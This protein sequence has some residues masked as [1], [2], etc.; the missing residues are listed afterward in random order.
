MEKP[1]VRIKPFE[2]NQEADHGIVGEDQDGNDAGQQHQVHGQLF[3]EFHQR[4]LFPIVWHSIHIPCNMILLPESTAIRQQK[5]L[6]G[7]IAGPAT[8]FTAFTSAVM[9]S[10]PRDFQL[11][12]YL[13]NS[14]TGTDPMMILVKVSS[15]SCLSVAPLSVMDTV[16]ALM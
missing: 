16:S 12:T 2:C 3:F 13:S 9:S 6:V 11:E 8:Y 4:G 7:W 5:R 15:R 14:S 1:L 10:P